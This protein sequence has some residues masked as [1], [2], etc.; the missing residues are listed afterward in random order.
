MFAPIERTKFTNIIFDMS[1]WWLCRDLWVK[2]LVLIHIFYDVSGIENMYT[3]AC[4][5]RYNIRHRRVCYDSHFRQNGLTRHS[6]VKIMYNIMEH[7]LQ[8]RVG[9]KLYTE[10]K[11]LPS[12]F[13]KKTRLGAVLRCH[14]AQGK[15]A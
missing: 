13:W 8:Q 4:V 5:S 2:K 1:N 7:P 6:K 10:N 14:V 15:V 12:Y 3:H 9:V 11:T